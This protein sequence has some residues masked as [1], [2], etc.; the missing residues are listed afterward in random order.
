M[1]LQ[2]KRQK[3]TFESEYVQYTVLS[4]SE[5]DVFDKE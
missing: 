1:P 2:Q 5:T 3:I 4:D